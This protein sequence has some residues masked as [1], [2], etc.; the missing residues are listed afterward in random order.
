MSCKFCDSPFDDCDCWKC[1]LL[2]EERILLVNIM[3]AKLEAERDA[4]SIIVTRGQFG[5]KK[6]RTA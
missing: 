2:P 6:R 5:N 1:R 3:L 4:K